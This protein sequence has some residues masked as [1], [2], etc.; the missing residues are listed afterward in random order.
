MAAS[1]V[2]TVN[3]AT[4]VQMNKHD[5]LETFSCVCATR[6]IRT[7][8]LVL[9]LP[10]PTT[11]VHR[12]RFLFSLRSSSMDGF[13]M[14]TFCLNWSTL[15]LAIVDTMSARD[16]GRRGAMV[17]HFCVGWCVKRRCVRVLSVCLQSLH[18]PKIIPTNDPL[19]RGRRTW[20]PMLCYGTVRWHA[21]VN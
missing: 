13:V 14:P 20:N 1:A 18:M 4:F 6:S 17:V 7:A 16:V 19:R 15:W 3:P 2:T 8:S 12:L 5:V 9:D 21:L 11:M 10:Q